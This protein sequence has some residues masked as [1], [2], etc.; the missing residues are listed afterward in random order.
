MTMA[1]GFALVLSP[2]AKWL[3]VRLGAMDIPM[4]RKIH[5]TPIPRL[6]GLAVFFAFTATMALAN[7]FTT[8]VSRLFV[9]D[10]RTAFGL[11][12]GLLVFGCGLWDDFRRLNPWPKLL[13]QILGASL[14]FAGG[15]FDQRGLPPKPRHPVRH[16][17]LRDH[18]LLVSPFHQRREPDRRPGRPGGW[19]G[20]IHL[21]A[22]G[23]SVGDDEKL[24]QWDVLCGTGRGVD[25]GAQDRLLGMPGSR[26]VLRV[27]PLR[28]GRG[29]I[30]SGAADLPGA[31]A[32]CEPNAHTG[33]AVG[34]GGRGTGDA[35][36]R[37]GGT[38]SEKWSRTSSS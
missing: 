4:E 2:V 33:G 34:A 9:F 32:R 12:G 30:Q 20:P 6:G 26:Q 28:E 29:G 22:D 21:S 10:Q 5:T 13:L 24:S 38:A 25:P 37:P 11:Y 15:D 35:E 19:G 36:V 18:G 7:L 1:L 14:A 23:R 31:A 27:V 8:E 17:Q 16:S 3:G